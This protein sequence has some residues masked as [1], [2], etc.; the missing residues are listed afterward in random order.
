MSLSDSFREFI[1]IVVH[2]GISLTG[3][4]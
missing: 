1:E 4:V 3:S 2:G